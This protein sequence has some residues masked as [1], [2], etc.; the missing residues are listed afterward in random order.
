MTI[1]RPLGA[2]RTRN[3]AAASGAVADRQHRVRPEDREQ[4]ERLL[5]R[6][7]SRPSTPP[8]DTLLAGQKAS[9]SAERDDALHAARFEA[10]TAVASAVGGALSNAPV[11]NAAPVLRVGGVAEGTTPFAPPAISCVR[12]RAPG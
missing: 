4:V 6:T 5:R 2:E 12:P 8:C 10:R 1:T 11:R 3:S 9:I 7:P